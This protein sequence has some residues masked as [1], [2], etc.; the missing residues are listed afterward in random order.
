MGRP[1]GSK[2]QKTEDKAPKYSASIRV[3][4]K[5]YVSTGDSLVEA[6]TKLPVEGVARGVTVLVITHGPAT[7]EKIIPK[8]ITPRL[9]SGVP[10]I[11]AYAI[12][13]VAERFSL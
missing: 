9:F 11:R 7:Q 8:V 3:L 12:K 6:I 13:H 5:Q 4:G 10:S 1:K 2:N